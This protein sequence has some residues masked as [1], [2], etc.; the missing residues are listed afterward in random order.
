MVN[1]IGTINNDDLDHRL[2]VTDD[3]LDG[4]QGA[5]IMRGGDGNDTYIVDN[6][7]DVVEEFFDDVTSGYDTVQSSV[8][9]TLS[10]GIDRLI[11]TGTG[12]NSGTGNALDND[13]QGNS[14]NNTLDGLDGNDTISGGDGNDTIDGATATTQFPVASMLIL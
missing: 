2:S 10:Y 14:G 3:L 8:S 4:L 7:G 13:I 1:Y 5:D 11:L 6:L 12:S 9:F